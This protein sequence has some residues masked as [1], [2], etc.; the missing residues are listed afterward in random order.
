M[1]GNLGKSV[2][3]VREPIVTD[4]TDYLIPPYV[5][6]CARTRIG[7]TEKSVLSVTSV[8]AFLAGAAA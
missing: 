3:S 7:R 6:V 8:Q 5:C 1:S 2:T 4:R